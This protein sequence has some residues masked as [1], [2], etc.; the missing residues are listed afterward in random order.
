MNYVPNLNF[1]TLA[2]ASSALKAQKIHQRLLPGVEPDADGQAGFDGG[3]VELLKP[4]LH[5]NV[6][7]IDVSS[8]YPSIMLRYGICSRKDTEN[9]FLGVLEYMRSERLRLKALGKQGDQSASFQEKALKVLINGSYGLFG[10]GY[11]TDFRMSSPPNLSNYI[12]LRV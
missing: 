6:A 12:S 10:I 11:Y 3:T 5:S 4:G 1:Q 2:I 7:K 9:R 8:L